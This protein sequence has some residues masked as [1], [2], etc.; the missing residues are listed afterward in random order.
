M[1]RRIGPTVRSIA[2][3]TAALL[4]ALIVLIPEDASA[5]WRGTGW[6]YVGWGGYY[7]PIYAAPVYAPVMRVAPVMAYPVAY[8]YPMP[9]PAYGGYYGYGY[10]YPYGYRCK[11]DEGHGRRGS[12]DR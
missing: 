9:Y 2:T 6:G 8:G 5:Y 10:G 7:R 1:K 11:T 4:A 3:G 12:C